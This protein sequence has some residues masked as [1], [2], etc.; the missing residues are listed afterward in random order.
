MNR[1]E[2]V[3]TTEQ[4][5]V[6]ENQRDS[7][8]ILTER[9]GDITDNITIVSTNK[10][11]QRDLKK[12]LSL[13]NL[14]YIYLTQCTQTKMVFL[15]QI[16]LE[17]QLIYCLI[18][19][20]LG[21]KT[22]KGSDGDES[23]G[24]LSD[25]SEHDAKSNTVTITSKCYAE[26]SIQELV[27]TAPN[28][29]IKQLNSK[30]LTKA[31]KKRI[32]VK[33]STATSI[34]SKEDVANYRLFDP[35]ATIDDLNAEKTTWNQMVQHKI[36]DLTGFEHFHQ[37]TFD[38]T[39]TKN[40]VEVLVLPQVYKIED[41]GWLKN[42]RCK[43]ICLA[44][45]CLT[46]DQVQQI[47]EVS[48]NV[49]IMRVLTCRG[50]DGRILLP[51]LRL[52]KIKQLI[53][54]DPS[55][56]LQEHLDHGVV[57]DAEWKKLRNTS[58]ETL[59][60]TSNGL[61]LDVIDHLMKSATELRNFVINNTILNKLHECHKPGFFAEQQGYITFI[62]SLSD[63]RGFKVKKPV[64]VTNL[65]KNKYDPLPFSQSMVRIAQQNNPEWDLSDILH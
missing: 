47:A 3:R 32:K 15:I 58:L 52:K 40:K 6:V 8:W 63:K 12:K 22:E 4:K 37:S 61:T 16:K 17:E 55:L 43:N 2:H 19:N 57:A 31:K 20:V 21:E 44:N 64:T 54:D 41:F 1:L 39:S 45:L 42:L 18:H 29:L 36:V 34:G 25:N 26:R 46:Q 48:P 33:R 13:T 9:F 65:L 23:D 38:Q 49:E 14:Q 28:G 60:I 59:S 35:I 51:L 10:T 27:R 5:L 11:I 62:S 53:I 7:Q 56:V 24:D 50:I 30:A